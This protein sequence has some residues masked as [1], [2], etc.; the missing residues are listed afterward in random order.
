MPSSKPFTSSGKDA[1]GVQH[2]AGKGDKPRHD[3]DK[4]RE[5]YEAI[6]WPPKTKGRFRKVYR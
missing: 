5:G 6:T 2:G 4:F 3:I 1:W